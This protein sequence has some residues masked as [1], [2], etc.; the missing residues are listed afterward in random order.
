MLLKSSL[1]A[2]TAELAATTGC[3]TLYLLV[4]YNNGNHHLSNYRSGWLHGDCPFAGRHRLQKGKAQ[5]TCEVP[6][7]EACIY[8]AMPLLF[9]AIP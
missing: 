7:L 9:M 1:P 2:E 4:L 6:V 3:G 8:A 5:G